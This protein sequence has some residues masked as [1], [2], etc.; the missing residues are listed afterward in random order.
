VPIR[1][2]PTERRCWSE[3]V[4]ALASRSQAGFV[5]DC[6]NSEQ[7]PCKTRGTV[8]DQRDNRVSGAPIPRHDSQ[9]SMSAPRV[10]RFLQTPPSKQRRSTSFPARS[11]RI[12]CSGLDRLGQIADKWRMPGEQA[13]RPQEARAFPD[14]SAMLRGPRLA[15]CL[16]ECSARRV[17]G[18]SSILQWV[19]C[20]QHRWCRYRNDPSLP[21][22]W[23]GGLCRPVGGSGEAVTA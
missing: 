12:Q 22:I 8:F 14:R 2:I 7:A 9:P 16:P 10:T 11:A 19:R 23:L 3:H 17:I 1:P 5:H 15:R 18:A 13:S 4:Q 20:W 6:D 21:L